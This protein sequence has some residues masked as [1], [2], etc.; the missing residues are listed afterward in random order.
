M[1]NI[2]NVQLAVTTLLKARSPHTV[3]DQLIAPSRRELSELCNSIPRYRDKGEWDFIPDY[4]AI[5][6]GHRGE[7]ELIIVNCSKHTL[8]LTELGLLHVYAKIAKP[9]FALQL[10]PTGLS[11]DLYSLL[12]DPDIADRLLEYGGAHRIAISSWDKGSNSFTELF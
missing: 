4:L 9:L 11:R 1:F 3:I 10:V 2:V 7:K 5:V 12:L 8:G 6:S